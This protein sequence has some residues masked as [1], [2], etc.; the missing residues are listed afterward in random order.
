MPKNGQTSFLVRK[1]EQKS[2]LTLKKNRN[3]C[4]L[5][6]Q[7]R[8]YTYCRVNGRKYSTDLIQSSI[9][10]LCTVLLHMILTEIIL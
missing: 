9:Q 5:F 10:I 8:E 7:I 3:K 4:L 2:H 6:L 1:K